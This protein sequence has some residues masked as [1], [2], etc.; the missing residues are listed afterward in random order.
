MSSIIGH[1][2]VSQSLS[3][4]SAVNNDLGMLGI[5]ATKVFSRIRT[6]VE[7]TRTAGP[8]AITP[9]D[10]YKMSL[11]CLDTQVGFFILAAIPGRYV[12]HRSNQKAR[13]LVMHAALD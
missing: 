13:C 11:S 12:Y 6:Q 8:D 4:K 1:Q 5:T 7:D 3:L 2:F 10:C 9:K